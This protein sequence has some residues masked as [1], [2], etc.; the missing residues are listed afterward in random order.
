MGQEVGVASWDGSK[1]SWN[2]MSRPSSLVNL[3]QD[4]TGLFRGMGQDQILI[5]W[6][7]IGPNFHF[8]G[9][10]RIGHGMKLF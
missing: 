1:S 2:K 8:V 10:D 3:N 6:D 4:G 9:W 7:R 5:S